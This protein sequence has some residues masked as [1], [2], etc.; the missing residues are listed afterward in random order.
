MIQTMW[1]MSDN[2]ETKVGSELTEQNEWPFQLSEV[3]MYRSRL[4]FVENAID[5]DYLDSYYRMAHILELG[6]IK[7]HDRYYEHKKE[8]PFINQSKH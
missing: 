5:S 4:N 1:L 6:K 2:K 3:F 8:K 7:N